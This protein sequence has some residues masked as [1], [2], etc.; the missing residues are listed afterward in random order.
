[1]FT[2]GNNIAKSYIGFMFRVMMAMIV[3][4]GSLYVICS[5][6]DGNTI[7]LILAGIAS[8]FLAWFSFSEG[9]GAFDKNDKFGAGGET[10][11]GVA[12]LLFGVLVFIA[13]FC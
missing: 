3:V 6:A 11:F 7:R 5:V 8:F 1:M 12:F 9:K 2:E 13:S 10:I 4:L